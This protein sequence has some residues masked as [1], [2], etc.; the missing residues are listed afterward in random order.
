MIC[1]LKMNGKDKQMKNVL[2]TNMAIANRSFFATPKIDF[3][4]IFPISLQESCL[5]LDFGLWTHFRICQHL[6]NN[7]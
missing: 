1:V 2:D 7:F 4:R 5:T 6:L 3:R